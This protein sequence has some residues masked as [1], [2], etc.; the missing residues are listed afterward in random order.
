MLHNN[1]LFKGKVVAFIM[2][3]VTNYSQVVLDVFC[4]AG[5]LSLL[6]AEVAQFYI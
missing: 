1:H 5:V 3:M 4:G 6:A 2:V